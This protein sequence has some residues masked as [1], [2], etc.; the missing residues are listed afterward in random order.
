MCLPPSMRIPPEEEPENESDDEFQLVE[1]TDLTSALV[2]LTMSK[3]NMEREHQRALSSSVCVKH[4]C[5]NHQKKDPILRVKMEQALSKL[6][7]KARIY[8]MRANKFHPGSEKH[9][10][11]TEKANTAVSNSSNIIHSLF[12]DKK[13]PYS[14]LQIM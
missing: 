10:Y 8:T 9:T 1:I 7:E 14:S 13:Q 6:A 5:S 2:N 4:S 3:M 11:W 12:W